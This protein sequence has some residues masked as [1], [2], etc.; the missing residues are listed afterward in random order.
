MFAVGRSGF[1]V[2]RRGLL[3]IRLVVLTMA[4]LVAAR[5]RRVRV[6]PR[7]SAL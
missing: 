7:F 5:V 1:Y 6:S 4:P 3:P 2:V